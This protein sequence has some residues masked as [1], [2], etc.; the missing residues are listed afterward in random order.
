MLGEFIRGMVDLGYASV[1]FEITEGLLKANF[2]TIGD[3]VLRA[4]T[5]GIDRPVGKKGSGPTRVSISA[6]ARLRYSD[7]ATLAKLHRTALDHISNAPALGGV[8][9]LGHW[10]SIIALVELDLD[11]LDYTFKGAVGVSFIAKMLSGVLGDLKQS[12]QPY[13]HE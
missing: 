8:R 3:P 10:N 5:I 1:R 7:P 12:I 2:L 4:I 11:P 13:V 6:E 9:L